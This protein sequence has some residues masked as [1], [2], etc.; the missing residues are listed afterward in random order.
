MGSNLSYGSTLGG[1]TLST[2]DTSDRM[3][4]GSKRRPHTAG[5]PHASQENS[6]ERGG[7]IAG[8]RLDQH[9]PLHGTEP[10]VAAAEAT[11]RQH[12]FHA[13]ER[14]LFAARTHKRSRTTPP[15]PNDGD[16]TSSEPASSNPKR[17][18]AAPAKPRSSCHR[19]HEPPSLGA[20]LLPTTR[21]TDRTNV[22]VEEPLESSRP[23]HSSAFEPPV[24]PPGKGLAAVAL[25]SLRSLGV[26]HHRELKERK[27]DLSFAQRL[28]Q[29]FC[30]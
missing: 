2:L 4:S 20:D 23:Q 15:A 17:R 9:E 22:R 8:E 10:S 29:T 14:Q 24:P 27:T 7:D 3:S 11:L 18:T 16:G 28:L 21:Q 26:R 12:A 1:F 6:L 25:T 19:R 13:T 30:R 5:D